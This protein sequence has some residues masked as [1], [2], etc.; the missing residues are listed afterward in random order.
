MTEYVNGIKV[1]HIA[2]GVSGRPEERFAKSGWGH[3]S[4]MAKT[5]EGYETTADAGRRLGISRF[6][7]RK[8]CAAGK[9]EHIRR[10]VGAKS[11]LFVKKG[12]VP[13]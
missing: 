10:G 2:P 11:R 7:V 4:T 12:A 9:L 13:T 1:R 5:P 3:I 6:T 8:L